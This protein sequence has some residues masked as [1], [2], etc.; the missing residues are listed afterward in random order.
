MKSAKDGNKAKG[1][2]AK[3]ELELEKNLVDQLLAMESHTKIS[4]SDLV[5]TAL[6]RFIASHKDYFPE[7][8][9]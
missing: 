4:K 7:E 9:H 8:Q 5:T 6:K 1:P 3:V 2:V